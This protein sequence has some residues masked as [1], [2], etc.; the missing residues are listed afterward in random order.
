MKAFREFIKEQVNIR[1]LA[2]ISKIKE[3][4]EEEYLENIE[5]RWYD[6]NKHTSYFNGVEITAISQ[7]NS[8]F[9]YDFYVFIENKRKY[10]H[11]EG[12]LIEL[13]KEIHGQRYADFPIKQTL[14]KL[15]ISIAKKY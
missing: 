14:S 4:S 3:I 10:L 6:E 9:V 7:G 2:S 12:D 11:F 5:K 15:R 8:N 1:S 13:Q